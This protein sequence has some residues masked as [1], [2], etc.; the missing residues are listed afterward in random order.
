MGASSS[1]FVFYHYP[2]LEAAAAVTLLRQLD[3][4]PHVSPG[5]VYQPYVVGITENTVLAYRLN[6]GD[7][8][9]FLGVSPR[10]DVLEYLLSFTKRITIYTHVPPAGTPTRFVQYIYR[11][12]YTS[13]LQ[14]YEL[15]VLPYL[16]KQQ[17]LQKQLKEQVKEGSS[18]KRTTY[19]SKVAAVVPCKK[20]EPKKEDLK[21]EEP[22][23]EEPKKEGKDK[24]E[25]APDMKK[26]V[27]PPEPKKDERTV[28]QK[29]GA[30][31]P[32]E[33]PWWLRVIDRF[34]RASS[35]EED[36]VGALYALYQQL[37]SCGP[38]DNAIVKTM[39]DFMM[40]GSLDD[41]DAETKKHYET[42]LRR[43]GEAIRK[44]KLH[45][46]T[47]P[48]EVSKVTTVWSVVYTDLATPIDLHTVSQECLKQHSDAKLFIGRLKNDITTH[49]YFVR[50]P[51]DPT[52]ELERLM[53]ALGNT[54]GEPV[55]V[56][57]HVEYL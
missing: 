1:R 28:L 18:P 36:P 25:M 31:N 50:N 42:E 3:D 57:E 21:K 48:P 47:L 6:V 41:V 11:H 29:M 19:A 53:V 40:M 8:V 17:Q 37:I 43:C 54:N 45:D 56:R 51:A 13:L 49:F 14:I 2:S 15:Y 32:S 39:S 55:L 24:L 27:E 22:K 26:A 33:A 46:W 16:Q 5:T 35:M 10:Q 30:M 52:V 20:E 7:H 4:V 9:I 23:K 34:D 44:A 38:Q 12:N